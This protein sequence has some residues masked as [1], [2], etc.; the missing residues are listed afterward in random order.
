MSGALA[1]AK[2][3]K[4][5]ALINARRWREA[6][7]LLTDASRADPRDAETWCMLG[8]VNGELN[9][10]EDAV[11][12]LE[13]AV[14]LAPGYADA[15]YNLAQAYMHKGRYADA[16]RAFEALL[17]IHPGHVEALNSLGLALAA[18]GMVRSAIESF[19]QVLRIDRQHADAWF[20]L[21]SALWAHGLQADAVA[22]LREAVHFR[23]DAPAR[24]I[25]LGYCLLHSARLDEAHAALDK[26]RT[27]DPAQFDAVYG[28][29][30]VLERRGEVA[31]AWELLRPGYESGTDELR[32]FQAAAAVAKHTGQ[33]GEIAARLALALEN[34]R[35][36]PNGV[37]AARFVLARLYEE[38]GD[39]DRAFP[40]FASV[41][42]AF[43]TPDFDPADWLRRMAAARETFTARFFADAPRASVLSER[44]VFIVGMPRSG[45]TL[46][47]Q[48][49]ASHPMVFGAGELTTMDEVVAWLDGQRAGARYPRC[50]E[51]AD[52]ALLDTAAS[53]YLSKLS[54]LSVDA[55]RVTDKLPHNFMHLGLIALLF[56]RAHIVHC[57]RHPVDNCVS[58]FTNEFFASH[59][60]ATDLRRLGEH[61]RAYTQLMHH[62]RQ[63]LPM[64]IFELRYE[65]LV[66][67]PER[68]TLQ[69][70]E[71]L[72]LPWDE[73]CLRFYELSRPVN[74]L[75]YDQVR[76]PLYR[77][78]IQRWRHYEKHLGPLVE[79]LGDMLGEFP[80][81]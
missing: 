72:G 56:P 31:R 51:H 21:G 36:P 1:R 12:C 66:A 57:S 74:T 53:R 30:M 37:T 40:H 18:G 6:Q 28:I 10:Y 68:T 52:T 60:Y 24:W 80:P 29:A 70:L 47:E 16:T 81:A 54:A 41:R 33:S 14:L 58:I 49:V 11:A 9:L 71:F 48:I 63:V 5:L 77:Q 25:E 38:S 78:S 27:L 13:K 39:Y 44:P 8:A 7:S 55:P 20:N 19:Q 59:S 45:T 75:S 23:P 69:L 4:A 2:R 64:P 15:Q 43:A 50:L 46:A 26:A 67:E 22:A 65:D 35:I 61:Y 76:R 62:W 17:R 3:R 79:S 42:A 73:R 32:F 34:G